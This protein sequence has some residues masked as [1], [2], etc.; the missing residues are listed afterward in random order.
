MTELGF[1]VFDCDN[2]YYEAIDAFTRHLDPRTASRTIE[3]CTINGRQYH[4][5]GGKVS[6]AVVNPTFDPVALPGVLKDYFRGNPKNENPIELL[7]Q[8]EPIRPAYRDKDARI[9]TLD[10]H[11]LEKCWMFPTLGMIY[12][13]PLHQ[14]PWAVMQVFTAFNRWMLEDWAFNYKDRIFTAPYISLVDVDWAISELEFALDNGATTVVMRPAAP[15]TVDGPR[16]PAD[17]MFDRFW[18][19]AN[20]SGIT[21]V[22]HAGDSGYNSHGYAEDNGFSAGFGQQSRPQPLRMA[23]MFDRPIEDFLGSLV[24]DKMLERFPNVRVASV[25]N[26]S[27]FLRGLLKKLDA[28]MNKMPGWFAEAPSETFRRQIWINPF[29]EDDV[30]EVV[31][32]V[33]SDRVIFGSDWPHIEGMPVPLDYVD[34]LKEFSPAVQEMIMHD[35]VTGLNTRRP[36]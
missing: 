21:V 13:E 22:A 20:E 31:E 30:H 25:E 28:T 19:L 11:G 5:I 34:E 6:H 7:K 8:R 3:W 9:A 12:E 1:P 27:G 32:L 2:H 29:W 24:C 35:N 23:T 10:D 15:T 18:G 4:V 26:G 36:A 33:G 14:D 16:S 17:P